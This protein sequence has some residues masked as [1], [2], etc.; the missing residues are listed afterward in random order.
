MNIFLRLYKLLSS[1][2]SRFL[3]IAISSV[4]FSI[5]FGIQIL[6]NYSYDSD[7]IFKL[8][9]SFTLQIFLSFFLTIKFEYF[10]I[11]KFSEKKLRF[12]SL[13]TQGGLFAVSLLL[14]IYCIDISAPYFYCGYYSLLI[15]LFIGALLFLSKSQGFNQLIPNLVNS[16]VI[17]F[18]LTLCFV[19][20]VMIIFWA[21]DTLLVN[22]DDDWYFVFLEGS[23]VISFYNFFVAYFTRKNEQIKI[24]KVFTVIVKRVLFTLYLILLLVLYLYLIKCLFN[25]K[26][27]VGK[28][29]WFVSF[30]TILYLFFYLTLGSFK[31]TKLIDCFYKFG[32]IVLIPLVVLQCYSFG[33]RINA[34][35]YTSL[36]YASLLYIIF[37]I[38][39][40]ALT[41]LK[42]GKYYRFIYVVFI[43]LT[44]FAGL[45]PWN[46]NSFPIKNQISRIE[47]IFKS[48][49]LFDEEK[50]SIYI[51]E[52][53]EDVLTK[54]E[55][56]K[57]YDSFNSIFYNRVYL[58]LNPDWMK[59]NSELSCNEN[60]E[61]IFKVKNVDAVVNKNLNKI[62]F[63][64]RPNLYSID[65]SKYNE[66]IRLELFLRQNKDSDN[67]KFYINDGKIRYDI[68][69]LIN[70]IIEN[71]S[72]YNNKY[73]ENNE[74][75]V[76]SIDDKTDLIIDVLLICNYNESYYINQIFGYIAK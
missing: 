4:A 14:F 52:N 53:L 6:G 5:V 27:P 13:L 61:N 23:L 28:I 32:F 2:L 42:N 69:N 31:G 75:L 9:Y 20:G 18:I 10:F 49:D 48:H 30:A 46:L 73:I 37:S 43:C 63:G 17:S 44:L 36:R 34:Y 22:V 8:L 39:F 26:M 50:N 74:L 70:D 16:L 7:T 64:Y 57:I 21:F 24:S 1:Q 35:G 47:S 40:I 45:S 65:V 66:I 68:S 29:N 55:I 76:Y 54:S 38:I 72:F 11:D 56:N 25:F 58:K 71:P 67:R 3:F 62:V 15:S 33:I 19:S 51:P 41:V 59:L 60:F 12:I